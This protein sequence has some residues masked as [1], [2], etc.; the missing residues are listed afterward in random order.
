MAHHP[1][2][3]LDRLTAPFRCY[4]ERRDTAPVT[5]PDDY[6]PSAA[7]PAAAA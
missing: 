3:L 6:A 2:S 4:A 7:R 1:R 5:V